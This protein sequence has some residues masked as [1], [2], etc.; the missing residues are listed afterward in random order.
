MTANLTDL[1]LHERGRLANIFQ[2]AAMKVNETD[3][4]RPR[5]QTASRHPRVLT[6]ST[7]HHDAPTPTKQGAGTPN[8]IS[9][10]DS[11]DEDPK[12]DST[13]TPWPYNTRARKKLQGSITSDTILTLLELSHTKCSPRTLAT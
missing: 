10:N 1:N 9:N 4:Q 11:D 6:T 8:Y 7:P 2:Q 13:P 12:N 5:V 3:A